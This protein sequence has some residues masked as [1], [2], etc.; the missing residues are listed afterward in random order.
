MSG[1]AGKHDKHKRHGHRKSTS[2][3]E[4]EKS[5]AMDAGEEE[6]K[7]E[8]E[9]HEKSETINK[10]KENKPEEVS[11]PLVEQIEQKNPEE[12]EKK[13]D[14]K[15]SQKSSSDS[16]NDSSDSSESSKKEV[17]KDNKK[18]STQK[19]AQSD[20]SDSVEKPPTPKEEKIKTENDD[21]KEEKKEDKNNDIK[22]NKKSHRKDKHKHKKS[23][24][25]RHRKSDSKPKS[26]KKSNDPP[27][28]SPLTNEAQ[29]THQTSDDESSSKSSKEH[30]K[31]EKNQSS[32]EKPLEKVDTK[33]PNK[34]QISPNNQ[35]DEEFESRPKVDRYGLIITETVK[36]SAEEKQLRREESIKESEREL[37]WIRMTQSYSTWRNFPRKV[38][39]RRIMKG[40]PDGMRMWAWQLILDPKAFKN[41]QLLNQRETVQSF[42]EKGR[43][44][45]C[46]IIEVDLPR[47]MPQMVMF[48]KTDAIDSLRSILHAYSNYDSDLGYTQG[49]AFYAAM[50][51]C[52]ME[53]ATA[54]W[55]FKEIMMG[56]S[57][58]L[59][60]FFLP[61]F[62]SLNKL[63]QVWEYYLN[64]K[65]KK[66]GKRFESIG[67]LTIM[68]APSWFMCN[69]LNSS[70][71]MVLK[72]RIFDCYLYFGTRAIFSFAIT[73]VKMHE[74]VLMTEPMEHVVPLLQRPAETKYMSDWRAV[75]KNWQANFLTKKQ[76]KEL[77]TKCKIEYI[78]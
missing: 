37:K 43:M 36:L 9:N 45:C 23:D 6:K 48:S 50:L 65:F 54:F 69:F 7:I 41:V 28:P 66:I 13:A 8:N 21:K 57:H 64:T 11:S 15:K 51:L 72:L 3:P 39:K 18:N 2:I 35:A 25:H 14:N 32:P 74:K 33:S 44:E 52:Y 73:I 38:I 42:V 59:R 61:E 20:S 34:S 75:I 47:T 31:T 70:F 62:P 60:N 27:P 46:N 1:K 76:Y 78:P 5:K 26:E 53:E 17:S 19:N 40:I 58:L 77:F 63:T 22:E 24:R 71:P 29:N 67:V 12:M 56:K 68:Y 30:S 49:M 4:I 16:V 10:N 55:C